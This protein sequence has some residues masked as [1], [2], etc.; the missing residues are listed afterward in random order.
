MCI[1]TIQVVVWP[2]SVSDPVILNRFFSQSTSTQN[3]V[4]VNILLVGTPPVPP[5]PTTQYATD[6]TAALYYPH[7]INMMAQGGLVLKM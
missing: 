7:L 4:W 6:R 5:H 3:N 2:K 1:D